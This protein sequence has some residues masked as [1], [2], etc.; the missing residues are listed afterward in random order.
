ML[1]LRFDFSGLLLSLAM[2]NEHLNA[3][4]F[5]QSPVNTRRGG[6]RRSRKEETLKD[7]VESTMDSSLRFL[8]EFYLKLSSRQLFHISIQ[9]R[10]DLESF[11]NRYGNSMI[12]YS[13]QFSASPY[14]VIYLIK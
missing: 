4:S 10:A 1:V 3:S 5:L 9:G 12:G 7:V 6:G 11:D 14:W 13:S 8:E 2:T